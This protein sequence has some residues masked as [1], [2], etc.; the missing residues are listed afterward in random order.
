M[1]RIGVRAPARARR[2]QRTIEKSQDLKTA[3]KR[4]LTGMAVLLPEGAFL[5]A[6]EDATRARSEVSIPCTNKKGARGRPCVARKSGSDP[7][8]DQ[9]P[10]PAAAVVSAAG[11]SARPPGSRRAPARRPAP[12]GCCGTPGRFPPGSGG[13][14]SRSPS[15]RAGSSRLPM[16]AASVSTRVVSWNE[17]AEM[18]ESV[19]S[20][21]LVM[22]SSM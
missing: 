12:C 3:A 21:A 22:P 4:A 2:M 1:R 14:R 13:R 9:L 11:V 8:F 7:D 6:C 20:E 19:D 10:P 17:A 15:G 18:N 5:R 16:I